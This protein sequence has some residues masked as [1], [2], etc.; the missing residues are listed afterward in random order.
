MKRRE[1]LV[2][3]VTIGAAIALRSTVAQ[4]NPPNRAAVVIGVDKVGSL[5]RLHAAASGAGSVAEW[6]TGEGF[7]VK[8]LIDDKKP[9][10]VSDLFDAVAAFTLRPTL[11]QLVLD[12]AG[13]GFINGS[14][15]Y[16]VL[17]GAPDNPNEAVSVGESIYLAKQ[18]SIPNVVIISDA[19]RSR[20]ESL[21][22]ERV[23]GSLIF[24]NRGSRPS[25][26][27]DVD[28]FYATLVG[29][30]SWEVSVQQ[31]AGAFVGIFTSTFLDAY[32]HPDE[33]MI[34]KKGGKDVIPNG[35]LKPYLVREVPRRAQA[36]SILIT[37][38]PDVQVVSG[39][40]QYLGQVTTA[41]RVPVDAGPAP[42]TVS[43]VAYASFDQI[44]RW[45]SGPVIA[46]PGVT[47]TPQLQSL[48]QSS[49]FTDSAVKIIQARGFAANVPPHT[50]LV[51]TGAS[52]ASV[53]AGADIHVKVSSENTDHVLVDIELLKARAG[54]VAIRFTDGSGF[55]FAALKDY[56]GSVVVDQNGVASVSYVPAHS[57]P[58]YDVSLREQEHLAALH[59]VVATSARF[60]VFRIEGGR[61]N[62]ADARKL[63]DTIR[64]LKGYDATLGIYAAYAYAQADIDEQVRSVRG[65]MRDVYGAELFDLGLLSGALNGV[66]VKIS[67]DLV[68]VFPMLTQ[69]WN[70]LRVKDVR[71]P[72]PIAKARDYLRPSLWTTFTP[73]GMEVI[74]QELIRTPPPK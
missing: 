46:D 14:F 72:I 15:E 29:D 7:D 57:N 63:G 60:G 16:W 13:H 17:S 67:P 27:P 43:G 4:G 41:N 62:Q 70:L 1:L 55:V 31:S 69:G 61:N 11:E 48:A 21:G 2:G 12:F 32:R 35:R 5:P 6:L 24:P 74:E 20:A 44:A 65:F 59:A 64:I 9:V 23:R 22:T 36:A 56:V 73:A 39:E 52:V 71:L 19:C 58:F 37:Q 42:P 54:S 38:R 10:K 53:R 47:L 40:S 28:V 45:R 18:T 30:P 49:G 51:V 25:V 50:G 3:G 68:P 8:L 66:S 34:A 26:I 33:S